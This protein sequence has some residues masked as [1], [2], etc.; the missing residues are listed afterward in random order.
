MDLETIRKRKDEIERS[1]ERLYAEVERLSRARTILEQLQELGNNLESTWALIINGEHG[2][3]GHVE[4]AGA[5]EVSLQPKYSG[6]SLMK[7]VAAAVEAFD[8]PFSTKDLYVELFGT[9]DV[10]KK[11]VL[12]ISNYVHALGRKGIISRLSRGVYTRNGSNS[13]LNV[14]PLENPV[15][16]AD[17]F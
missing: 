14:P 10:P 4:S 2:N 15:E 8:K 11:Y 1:M 7:A 5:E 16:E 13:T 3:G 6:M 17:I 12:T 9:C